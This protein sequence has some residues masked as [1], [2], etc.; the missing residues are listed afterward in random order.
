MFERLGT[1]QARIGSRRHYG[2][3][4]GVAKD[5]AAAGASARPRGHAAGRGPA[6][7]D[8]PGIYK[9]VG[10][11]LI[12]LEHIERPLVSIFNL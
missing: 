11:V 12:N 10:A 2:L 9:D 4:R 5:V 6:A 3:E 8:L 7:N 1:D